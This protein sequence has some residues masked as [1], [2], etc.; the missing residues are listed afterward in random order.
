MEGTDIVFGHQTLSCH[1][2]TRTS[3]PMKALPFAKSIMMTK[4]RVDSLVSINH[5]EI[6]Q[7]PPIL[8][9]TDMRGLPLLE[10]EVLIDIIKVAQLQPESVTT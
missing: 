2:L 1:N 10:G 6:C 8:D 5:K 7:Q 4:S 9:Q 3:F